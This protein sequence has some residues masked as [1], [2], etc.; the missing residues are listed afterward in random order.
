MHRIKQELDRS[1]PIRIGAANL[2][3]GAILEG[4]VLPG[5]EIPQLPLAKR[6]G[7]S[8]S[9]IREALQ[10]LEYRGMIQKSGRSW[11]VTQLSEDEMADLYQVRALL[12]PHACS[13]A[14]AHWNHDAGVKL[15]DCLK[16]MAKAA[17][18]RNYREHWSADIDFH[19]TIWRV[20]PNRFLER[21]LHMVCMPIFAHG[22]LHHTTIPESSYRR[23]IQWHSLIVELLRTR[24]AA[25]VTRVVS[26]IVRRFH[27]LNL[28]DFRLGA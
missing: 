27:R 11:K 24:D 20:Q 16:R 18:Q 13:L 21:Q 8:Q 5:Q 6:L 22:L 7:L 1:A 26:R 19:Q 23:S 17:R 14:A 9:S 28:E 15:E 10:E 2:I 25:R 4:Q 3:Q 12:E